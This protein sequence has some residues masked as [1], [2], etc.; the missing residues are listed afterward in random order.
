MKNQNYSIPN[1][2]PPYGA[3][4]QTLLSLAERKEIE[5]KKL[6][7]YV[8]RMFLSYPKGAVIKSHG[9]YYTYWKTEWGFKMAM[10]GYNMSRSEGGF[11]T[12]EEFAA[13][14]FEKHGSCEL[15]RLIKM[16]RQMWNDARSI[17]GNN[18]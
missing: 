18:K 2:R 7:E 14:L 8:A 3:T 5:R 10:T 12:L 15:L 16:M 13:H 17:V 6:A 11:P 4:K 1:F 9:M